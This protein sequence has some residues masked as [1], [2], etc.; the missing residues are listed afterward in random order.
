MIA[1]VLAVDAVSI[2]PDLIV[3]LLYPSGEAGV[4]TPWQ[5]RALNTAT[6]IAA[7][8][9]AWMI[10]TERRRAPEAYVT[11]AA[12]ALA[13]SIYATLIITPMDPDLV[14]LLPPPEPGLVIL[15]IALKVLLHGLVYWYLA[16]HRP[17]GPMTAPAPVPT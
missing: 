6:M 17:P 5:F 8:L 10:W 12:V 9:G 15:V 1:G 14:A 16:R 7:A 11:W 13:T 4:A 2:L 3:P